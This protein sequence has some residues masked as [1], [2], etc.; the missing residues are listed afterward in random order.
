MQTLLLSNK[1]QVLLMHVIPL[2]SNE[3]LILHRVEN[4]T[5]L[6]LKD[7]YDT[8]AYATTLYNLGDL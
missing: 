6:Q 4:H 7:N 1:E 5:R 2:T 3:T 8:S